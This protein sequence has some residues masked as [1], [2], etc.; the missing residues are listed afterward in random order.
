MGAPPD[1]GPPRPTAKPNPPDMAFG[2]A[3]HSTSFVTALEHGYNPGV[4]VPITDAHR[5]RALEKKLLQACELHD[6]G[7]QVMRQNLRR[8][9]P[10][11]NDV[12]IAEMIQR[13]LHERPGAEFGDVA[14]KIRVRP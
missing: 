2:R 9:H 14:G 1:Y 6:L 13:W 12:E 5:K 7:V 10:D 3:P 4:P 8:R 11:A